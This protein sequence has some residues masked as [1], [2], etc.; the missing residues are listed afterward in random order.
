MEMELERQREES[1]EIVLDLLKEKKYVPAR[2]ELLTNNS[3]D[4][5]E[6]LEEI[7]DELGLDVAIIMLRSLPKDV[8]ADVFAELSSDSQV[9]IIG[10]IT[11]KEI[12]YII[13]EMDFDDMIDVLE[14]LPANLVDKILDR[15]P[16]EERK[17]IN[18]FLHYPENSAGSI[19]TPEYISLKKDMTVSEALARI[20]A[21]GK[22]SE[23]I[24]TCYVKDESRRLIGLVSLRSMV[25]AESS[26]KIEDL[27]IP[28]DDLIC[29]NVLDDQETVS[30][31]FTRYGFL[32][33]PVVDKEER[34]VGIITVDDI[35]DIIEE[36]TTEDIQKMAG[37]AASTDEY[38]DTSVWQHMKNRLPWLIFLMIS[39]MITGAIIVRFEGLLSQVISLVSYLPLLMGTGGNSGSQAA[40]LVIRS[41]SIGEL[42][43]RD[44]G[45][46]FWKEIRVGFCAGLILSILNCAKILLIDGEPLLVAI[47][48]CG[49]LLLVIMLAKSIG[50]MLPLLAKRLNVDPALMASPMIASLNDLI[51][52]VVYFLLATSILGL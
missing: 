47:T 41:L 10:G 23:T 15:A 25:V 45:A 24:Y 21:H 26:T 5:A 3:V 8:V 19:M 39:S 50:A 44:A 35:L 9:E 28:S 40:T 32:A 31:L 14:E 52:V 13:A 27:M 38:L 46:V 37:V 11:D 42:D 18:T 29:V 33:L 4:I 49:S 20:R 7:R 36:E 16:K 30:S 12:S 48:V 43:L 22:D 2:Q 1:L 51:T 34:L 17:L 6:M